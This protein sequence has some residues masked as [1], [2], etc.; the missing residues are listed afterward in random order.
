MVHTPKL[1]QRHEKMFPKSSVDQPPS[2]R[3]TIMTN[4]RTISSNLSRRLFT[5][6]L[7]RSLGGTSW[8]KPQN[9]CSHNDDFFLM[10]AFGYRP[11]DR[12]P[13]GTN[14]GNLRLS[15]T[16]RSLLR[17][18]KGR[19]GASLKIGSMPCRETGNAITRPSSARPERF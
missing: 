19:N 13:T 1:L 9:C 6:P 8:H 17:G 15:W 16:H 5:M 3:R 12:R 18:G 11:G 10:A 7:K 14:S 2:V 4:E